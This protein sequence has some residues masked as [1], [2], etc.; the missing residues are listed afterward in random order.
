[1]IGYY[2]S[3]DTIETLHNYVRKCQSR[4]KT[5]FQGGDEKN[6]NCATCEDGKKLN[7]KNNCII[8][9]TDKYF[10][11]DSCIDECEEGLIVDETYHECI[12]CKTDEH[13]EQYS[14]HNQC[15]TV[16]PTGSV[17]LLNDESNYYYDC[18]ETCETCIWRGEEFQHTAF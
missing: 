9:C 11:S 3:N 7:R 8:E 1:M 12:N 16:Q 18:Y 10:Y 13:Y 6:Q 5:C 2:Y 15:L 17:V 4:C 14:Y